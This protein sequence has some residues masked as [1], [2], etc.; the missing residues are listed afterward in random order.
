MSAS[1][2]PT[3]AYVKDMQTSG[4]SAEPLVSILVLAYNH[5]AFIREA[6]RSVLAQNYGKYEI[7]IAEDAS[8]DGTRQII[9]ECL[10]RISPSVRVTKIY[11][12]IN[13][14]LLET[15]NE[16]AACASGD[17]LVFQAGDD[18]SLPNRLTLTV[19]AFM[20]NPGARFV[21]G[22]YF[23]MDEAG[24]LRAVSAG[25]TKPKVFSY[26]HGP[27]L[28]I[29]AGTSPMGAA[30][31]YHRSL[32]DVFGPIVPGPYGE[33]NCLLV[34]ALL[35]GEAQLAAEPFICWR[36]HAGNLSN[37]LTDAA[38]IT[39]RQRHLR[40]MES[41]AM[42]SAQW[43]RD[44]GRARQM[45]LISWPRSLRLRLAASREDAAW[46]L[47]VSSLRGDPW[48]EWLGR[49]GRLLLLGRPTSVLR[50]AWVRL[51][52]TVREKTWI[53]WAKMKSGGV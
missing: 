46:A 50:S 38:S 16:A 2:A 33:D 20:D 7:V 31:A 52:P 49:A 17:I 6:L 1:P 51:S 9:E 19:K 34:R 10:A 29:Y 14:G 26:D 47:S 4:F 32:F 44:I 30:A 53:W 45:N 25:R 40:W 35:L 28:R 41:H 12:D 43:R 22:E 48:S 5:E 18:V 27:L 8:S 37:F 42:M 15:L 24:N 13:R 23:P 21:W 3:A 39:W 11:H 36:Q